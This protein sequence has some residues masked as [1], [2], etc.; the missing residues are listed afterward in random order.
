MLPG[1]Q[2]VDSG[3]GGTVKDWDGD[4]RGEAEGRGRGAG[5]KKVK[6]MRLRRAVGIDGGDAMGALSEGFQERWD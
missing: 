3:D 4:G 2:Q 1:E 5:D 6:R